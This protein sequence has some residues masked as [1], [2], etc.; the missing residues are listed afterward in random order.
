MSETDHDRSEEDQKNKNKAVAFQLKS[1]RDVERQKWEEDVRSHDPKKLCEKALTLHASYREKVT[2]EDG[3]VNTRT[4]WLLVSQSIL[5]AALV[6][7]LEK[8]SS[9]SGFTEVAFVVIAAGAISCFATA[10]SVQAA[11]NAIDEAKKRW[12]MVRKKLNDAMVLPTIAGNWGGGAG[13]G[14]GKWAAHTTSLSLF[15]AWV[16]IGAIFWVHGVPVISDENTK[17]S[18]QNV[19]A[20]GHSNANQINGVDGD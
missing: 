5:F 1:Q 17:P 7:W 10:V 6:V 2:H 12:E 16:S 20:D 19:A 13:A 3:L 18:P 9:F 11:F 15:I 14:F 4:S 8:F